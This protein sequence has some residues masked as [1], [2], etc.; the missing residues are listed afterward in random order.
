MTR[1]S[2]PEMADPEYTHT[3]THMAQHL[4]AEHTN[5]SGS[6]A[7]VGKKLGY[8]IHTSPGKCMHVYAYL[9]EN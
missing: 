3:H 6:G 9:T 1:G 4:P 7:G 8:K 5:A 2:D